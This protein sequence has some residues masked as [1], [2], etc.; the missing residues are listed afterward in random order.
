MNINKAEKEL[1]ALHE[2][3]ERV[4]KMR[5]DVVV[6]CSR[7]IRDIHTYNY[8]VAK[9][10]LKHVRNKIRKLEN[11]IK[12]HEQLRSGIG[13]CYQEYVELEALLG[14]IEKGKLPELNVPAEYYLLGVLDAIGELKRRCIELLL[15]GK[16]KEAKRLYDK[17]EGIYYRMEGY[18]FPNALVPGF[19]HKQDI[20]KRVLES[21]YI[22]L[23]EAKIKK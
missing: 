13:L 10:K 9:E 3:R 8:S 21:L 17:M 16:E 19:K 20:A 4:I 7:A 22:I 6:L 5:R 15:N 23:V 2:M 18:S 12:K 1:L 11:I 14:I